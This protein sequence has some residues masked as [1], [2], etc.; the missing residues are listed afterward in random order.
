MDMVFYSLVA[1]F[2]IG[3]LLGLI[4]KK[5]DMEKRK[6]AVYSGSFNP[7]HIGHK[8][9]IDT[10]SKK[11]DW[12]YLV[13]TPQNPL[14]DNIETPSH[15]RS[16]K[17]HE[18][19][20]RNGYFNVSVNNVENEMMPPYYT[21]NTLRE[22]SNRNENGEFMLA[23]GADNLSNIKEWHSYKEILLDFGVIVFPRGA[24][25]IS[26][27]ENLKFELLKE[28]PNYKIEIEHTITPTI[29]STEIRNAIK[30]GDNVDNLL[31]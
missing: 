4:I 24:E 21:I 27:L 26:Y 16:Q 7:L 19:L 28:N 20:I 2:I 22:L 6:I 1:I 13:V 8:T 17:A 10:L 31:M 5:D 29:S 9:V 23:I 11:F 15:V 12:V 3:M 25:D 18:A 30:N 14:K